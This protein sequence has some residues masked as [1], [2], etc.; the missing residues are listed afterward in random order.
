MYT[1]RHAATMRPRGRR[2]VPRVLT[3]PWVRPLLVTATV[4]A[5]F[6]AGLQIATAA[7]APPVPVNQA[8]LTDRAFGVVVEDHTTA[9][10]RIKTAVLSAEFVE[11]ARLHP[12]ATAAAA[13][14]QLTARKQLLDTSLTSADLLQPE[15][16]LLLK[17]INVLLGTNGAQARTSPQIAGLVAAVIGKTV[18]PWDTRQ[19]LASGAL[20]TTQWLRDRD[21]ALAAV[22]TAVR[23]TAVSGP[24]AS[25]SAGA[26]V[27]DA[28]ATNA[29]AGAP[30]ASAWNAVL[31]APLGVNA[32]STLDQLKTD[33]ALARVDFDAILALKSDPAA[34]TAAAKQQADT[35]Q[36]SLIN[37]TTEI[38]QA[39]TK[40]PCP[41]AGPPTPECDAAAK[42]KADDAD[43]E[44]QET[45][46]DI[47]SGVDMVSTLL[48]FADPTLGKDAKGIGEAACTVASAISKYVAAISGRGLT[49]AVFS[50]ATLGMTGNIFGAVMSVVGLFGS[51]GPSLDAQILQ[52]VKAL[53]DQVRALATQMQ[54]S[55][56][57]VAAE[58]NTVYANMLNQFD[59]LNAAIVGNTAQL[60]AV[61][62]QV[63]QQGLRLED[64]ASTILAAIG[65]DTL[66]NARTD[67]NKYIGYQE[68]FGQPIP[69]FNEFT[70]PETDFLTAATTFASGSAFE[71]PADDAD[72]PAIDPTT[73]LNS[74]QED[75]TINYLAKLAS[76]RDPN[77]PAPNAP[78]GNP[79][80]WN[81]GAQSY[82]MLML[83]NPTYAAR[84]GIGRPASIESEG[85]RI[86]DTA[87][88]F[89]QPENG[90][91]NRLFQG[92]IGDYFS[93]T[94]DLKTALADFQKNKIQPR[95]EFD[96]NG[97]P[98]LAAKNYD[99]FWDTDK[100]LQPAP[101]P[102]D[103]AHV[104]S[105]SDNTKRIDLPSNVSF[106][107]LSN[108]VRLAFYAYTPAFDQQPPPAAH[109]IPELKRCYRASW[110]PTR[111]ARGSDGTAYWYGK[112]QLVID[113]Q[114]HLNA[115]APWQSARS[116]TYAWPEEVYQTIY[117]NEREVTK[118]PEQ[119]LAEHWPADIALFSSHATIV[120]NTALDTSLTKTLRTFLQARQKWMYDRIVR[121][122]LT[123]P[124]SP[125]YA[126]VKRMNTAA[127]LLQA[128]TRLGMP[129]ALESDDV[130]SANLFGQYQIPVNMPTDSR[131]AN[132]FAIAS[133]NY[134]CGTTPCP[135]DRGRPLRNQVNL[136][137]CPGYVTAAGDPLAYC[138]AQSAG[139]STLLLAGR[140]ADWAK[141]IA[142]GKHR[143]Q[144][145]WVA[146]TLGA[147]RI[148]TALTHT[149]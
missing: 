1:D 66:L 109:I 16:A 21:D 67:I 53:R 52:Q 6:A 83:Q 147:L 27:A 4:A 64:I 58:I 130:L 37:L 146:D 141:Q 34:Y 70:G 35:L 77:I 30:F 138:L 51:S 44:R 15:Q 68:N 54:A 79:A 10:D 39:V 61:Q 7:T 73:E 8:A 101:V 129:L 106:T 113:T 28:P 102:T 59:R 81:L 65:D 95:Y 127:R 107:Q 14:A 9:A 89:S 96:A 90:T 125:I 71:V 12:G 22:W 80:V 46:N 117:P 91:T 126:A 75:R 144:L 137:D 105:C 55:F 135:V 149:G 48:G 3:R 84:V 62:Q 120:S 47:K 13:Q 49:D 123:N 148:T 124:L 139:I 140:Y 145:P 11:W 56:Q 111:T 78:V 17:S 97:V 103:G 45:I 99:L 112:L 128:Y 115:D 98:F 134:A 76:E 41:P 40:V 85:Q 122:E 63:A 114:F 142:A 132:M 20:R 100:P 26:Q 119:G 121:D 2:L 19:D 133:H 69:T 25:G 108:P 32:T 94:T 74:Y 92:L 42:K 93:A 131:I 72:N 86:L 31:G 57:A 18:E 82:S 24:S 5:V 60:I 118:T 50:F 136:R 33:P 87:A 110:V 23:H 29:A 43:K 116:A 38:L 36:T 104:V 143:E 88:S